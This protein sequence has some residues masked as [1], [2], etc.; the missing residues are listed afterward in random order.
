VYTHGRD[1]H[2]IRAGPNYRPREG[3]PNSATGRAAHDHD[4]LHSDAPRQ[5]RAFLIAWDPVAGREV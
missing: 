1:Q 2:S 3:S 4:D 5:S